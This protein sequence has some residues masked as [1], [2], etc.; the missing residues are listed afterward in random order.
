MEAWYINR[1]SLVKRCLPFLLITLPVVFIAFLKFGFSDTST[2]WEV[3]HFGTWST[4]E[5]VE[6]MSG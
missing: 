1:L 4:R 3:S 6:V 2:T 5:V